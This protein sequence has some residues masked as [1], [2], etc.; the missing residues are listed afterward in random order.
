MNKKILV[1]THGRFGEELI[2]SAQMIGGNAFK[3][4]KAVSLLPS[5]SMD[6]YYAAV[7]KELDKD[8]YM[9]KGNIA[10][11]AGTY[12]LTIIANEGGNFTGTREVSYTIAK[13]NAKVTKSTKP[14]QNNT[15]KT[16]ESTQTFRWLSVMFVSICGLAGIILVSKKTRYKDRFT[17]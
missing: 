10:K 1:C 7:A 12:T 15:P 17:E 5:M 14:G 3:N 11:N 2:K 13:G 4:I 16:G 6:D 9:V 8:A